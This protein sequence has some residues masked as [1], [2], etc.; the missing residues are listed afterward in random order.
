MMLKVKRTNI[1]D[2]SS[3]NFGATVM[4]G[5]VIETETTLLPLSMALKEMHL[6]T[7]TYEGSPTEPVSLARHPSRPIGELGPGG[8]HPE[9]FGEATTDVLGRPSRHTIPDESRR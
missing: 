9:P 8:G 6:P 1:E 2:G 4:G 3:V 5:A 7:A